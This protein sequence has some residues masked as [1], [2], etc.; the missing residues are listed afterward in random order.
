MIYFNRKYFIDSFIINIIEI[1]FVVNFF[2]IKFNWKQNFI[3]KNKNLFDF[4]FD[5]ILYDCYDYLFVYLFGDLI[6]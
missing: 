2:I 3:R 5:F 1:F 4:F 6:L